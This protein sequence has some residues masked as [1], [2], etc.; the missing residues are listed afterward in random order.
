M[1]LKLELDKNY[2]FEMYNYHFMDLDNDEMIK[3]FKNGSTA[4]AFFEIQM[5]KWFPELTH[6][7]G[8]K[9]WD[10]KDKVGNKY[11]AKAFTKG[12]ARFMRSNQIGQGRTF[13]AESSHRHANELYYILHDIV[14]F[15]HVQVICR[16]GS[17]LTLEYKNC[18]IPFGAR[19][20]LF[21][22]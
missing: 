17:E 3:F 10:L 11:D 12:G 18:S 9:P 13:D 19:T 7:P 14:D 1:T 21:N 20:K 6:V 8:Q 2:Q 15:P 16:A 22:G 5:T 4:S